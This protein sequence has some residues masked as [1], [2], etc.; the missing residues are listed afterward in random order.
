MYD[1]DHARAPQ[2]D[3]RAILHDMEP[4]ADDFLG[5]AL[6]GL[7]STPK[8]LPHR[9]LYDA[10][11]SALFDRITR[12]PEYY[13]TRTEIGILRDNAADIAARVGPNVQLVELGSGSSVK[14]RILL[15]A[16]DNPY[17]YVPIDISRDHLAGAA[18]AIQDAYPDLRVEAI[19]ADF[20][21]P[22]DLPPRGAGKRV[23]FYPGSS[24]GNFTPAEAESFLK[25]WAGRLGAGAMM[26][27]G[28]DLQKDASILEA[29][30]DDAQKVTAAFS[31]NLLARANRE[32]D[33]DFDL[34]AFRHEARYR[35]DEGRVEI[36]L[37]ALKDTEVTL[38]GRRFTFEEGER[39][40][41][42][43]SWKYTLP[44]FRA[45]ADRAG[46]EAETVWID[47]DGLFSV[48]M[49]RVRP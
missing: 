32:L 37:V 38:D 20:A 15:D 26:L 17:A 28:V 47:P 9:F 27:I 29:A 30:Y 42:E 5:A 45:L 25:L 3:R 49:M 1:A 10:E 35:A 12:L 40:H 4:T 46:W 24:I 44:G 31:L 6:K 39:L 11:G 36:S 13:P 16:L 34:K 2:S 41:V 33:A 18:Q 22:F 8:A 21:Q 48:H 19:A 43:D 23:G 7:S 14:V